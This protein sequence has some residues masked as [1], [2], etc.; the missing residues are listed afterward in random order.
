MSVFHCVLRQPRRW[1]RLVRWEGGARQGQRVA[2]IAHVTRTGLRP[3]LFLYF[4]M[5][6]TRHPWLETS[7]LL[8]R[9]TPT[10]RP[11]RDGGAFCS[12]K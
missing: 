12:A 11:D 6:A 7:V 3:A 10:A 8:G 2:D 5:S 1:K 4:A 9:Q